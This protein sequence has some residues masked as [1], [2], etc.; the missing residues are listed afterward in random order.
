MMTI[1][2]TSEEIKRFILSRFPSARKWELSYHKK[3]LES[4][5][6]DS[7]GVLEVVTYLEQEF[8]ISLTDEDLV[9]ENF[10]TIENIT[11]FVQRK[12][13]GELERTPWQ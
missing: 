2:P 5:I 11:Q 1:D 8:K 3:L 6:L 12:S 4:G 10:Q 9:P 7:L 13:N